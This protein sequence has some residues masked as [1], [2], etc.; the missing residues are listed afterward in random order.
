M[1]I[2]AR[3]DRPFVSIIED[4]VNDGGETVK[5]KISDAWLCGDAS[6][7]LAITRAEATGTINNSD[8]LP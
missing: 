4:S 1:Q 8:P 3:T 5:V 7:T 6:Q 2:G